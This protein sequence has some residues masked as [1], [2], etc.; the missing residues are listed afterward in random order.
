MLVFIHQKKKNINHVTY[1]YKEEAQLYRYCAQGISVRGKKTDFFVMSVYVY[2]IK[3]AALLRV[4]TPGFCLSTPQF[5]CSR[6]LGCVLWKSECKQHR[7]CLSYKVRCD[8]NDGLFPPPP[9]PFLLISGALLFFAVVRQTSFNHQVAGVTFE[10]LYSAN[11][12]YVPPKKKRQTSTKKKTE[13]N[14]FVATKTKRGKAALR[15]SLCVVAFFLGG[16]GGRSRTT[17]PLSQNFS[18]KTGPITPQ[19]KSNSY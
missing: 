17:R 14:T 9:L 19:K 6:H 12:K 10:R 11:P 1:T 16:E 15:V 18:R 13:N 5:I 3:Q 8:I 7:H 4:G 2:V